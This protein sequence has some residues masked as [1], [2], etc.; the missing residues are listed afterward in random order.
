MLWWFK[1]SFLHTYGTD[2]KGILLRKKREIALGVVSEALLS[3][4]TKTSGGWGFVASWLPSVLFYAVLVLLSIC[5]NVLGNPDVG[6]G[7]FAGHNE[8]TS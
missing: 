5:H 1:I 8:K 3:L 7:F 4:G 6:V 2:H